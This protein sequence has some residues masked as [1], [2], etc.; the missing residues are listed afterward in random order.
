MSVGAIIPRKLYKNKK[1][2]LI[3]KIIKQEL[4]RTQCKGLNKMLFIMEMQTRFLLKR[5]S[6]QMENTS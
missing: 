2:N 6:F 4:R 5:I 1:L 3:K